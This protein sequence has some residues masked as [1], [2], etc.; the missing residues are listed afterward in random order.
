MYI[1]TSGVGRTT[2]HWRSSLINTPTL[3]C[4]ALRYVPPTKNHPPPALST[5][6]DPAGTATSSA[7][8]AVDSSG[9]SS[10]APPVA[11]VSF[12][13]NYVGCYGDEA[14]ARALTLAA[15]DSDTMTTEVR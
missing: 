4:P 6:Q 1:R 11:E 7:P 13:D 8:P 2:S 5:H 9:A 3:A 14:G 12:P 10:S 15:T